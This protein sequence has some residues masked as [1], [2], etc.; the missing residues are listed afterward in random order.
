MTPSAGALPTYKN[1]S[2]VL[3]AVVTGFNGLSTEY[4]DSNSMTL[5]A[6]IQ[7]TGAATQILLGVNT[8]TQ[9][10]CIFMSGTSVMTHLVRNAQGASVTTEIPVPAGLTAGKYI[11]LA[12]SRNSFRLSQ[13]WC[14]A[15]IVPLNRILEVVIDCSR[16][17]FVTKPS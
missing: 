6:V 1:S 8:G 4:H 11:F 9:G 13:L 10:E 5:A 15:Y 12:F 14:V 7:Y 16:Q 2:L 17:R 3:P